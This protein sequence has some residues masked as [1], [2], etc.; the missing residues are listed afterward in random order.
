MFSLILYYFMYV[1]WKVYVKYRQ[2][3]LKENSKQH[4]SVL[5]TQ[6]PQEIDSD[7]KL[8]NFV[9]QLFPEKVAHSHIIR[10]LD[11]YRQ[12]VQ[13][14]DQMVLKLEHAQAVFEE[15]G[16]RPEHKL[17]PII[18][19]KVD[20]INYFDE[21]L[22]ETQQELEKVNFAESILLDSAI[23]TFKSI[24]DARIA[25]EVLW[26]AIPY[27]TF[28]QPAPEPHDVIW[29]N[30]DISVLKK[31]IRWTIISVCLFFLVIFWTIP[32]AF[33]SAL[34]SLQSLQEKVEFLEFVNDFPTA[35]KGI[36]E[37]V[38][39]TIALVIFFAIL[40]MLMAFMSKKEGVIT[41]SGVQKSVIGKMFIFII[42]NKFLILVLSGAFLN[43]IQKIIDDPGSLPSLLAESLPAMALFFTNF[44]M[45]QALMGHA[46]RLLR[47]APLI[48][49]SIKTKWLA[50]TPRELKNVWAPPSPNYGVMYP[51]D[52]YIFIIG[53]AYCIQAPYVIPFVMLYFGFG[54]L[55]HFYSF[56]YVM[57]PPFH[58]GG[59]M[60]P[61]VFN[62]MLLAIVVFQILMIGVFGLKKNPEVS[63]LS[64]PPIFLTI[65]F[66]IVIMMYFERVAKPM[67]LDDHKDEESENKEQNMDDKNDDAV[68]D[69][70]IKDAHDFFIPTTTVPC[71]FSLSTDDPSE[72]DEPEKDDLKTTN[73]QNSEFVED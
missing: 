6:L 63:A 2:I 66:K 14:H 29:S 34:V 15:K 70:F 36:I 60:W 40:P 37:G 43:Q 26:Q 57:R 24:R 3:Y 56:V 32:V 28:V 65:I 19:E 10:D 16:E 54:Y 45:L 46:L 23:V 59:S 50:K 9:D 44:A 21:Q 52:L 64:L 72:G 5:V 8:K 35:L 33:V 7:D 20:S 30:L 73:D 1:E 41:N 38:L 27:N 13:K 68:D 48:I 11:E 69:K 42:V 49:V 71:L 61:K 39:S 67:E 4:F 51:N 62:R 58:A 18:G 53:V 31:W 47:I 25:S 55:V 17:K 22:R 12:L